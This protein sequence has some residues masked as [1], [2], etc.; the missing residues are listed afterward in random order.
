MFFGMGASEIFTIAL[1]ALLLVGPKDLPAMFRTVGG[2][3]RGIL[4]LRREF[5][6]TVNDFMKENDLDDVRHAADSARNYKFP[7]AA[8][9][10]DPDGKIKKDVDDAKRDVNAFMNDVG[11]EQQQQQQPGTKKSK[12]DI[13]DD[14]SNI[15]K[16]VDSDS[17]P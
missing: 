10:L 9:F 4:S 8:D 2:W 13:E 1:L 12:G 3:W 11:D 15:K 5:Q 14:N 6:S 17:A 7:S 16:E